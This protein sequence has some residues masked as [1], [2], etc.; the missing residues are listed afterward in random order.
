MTPII[1]ISWVFPN[2]QIGWR[3]PGIARAWSVRS[4]TPTR[5]TRDRSLWPSSLDLGNILSSLPRLPRLPKH[6]LTPALF[7]LHY[8]L[9]RLQVPD[10][11]IA[12]ESLGR[13]H[14]QG[15]RLE[16]S[17]ENDLC[18]QATG[19][20]ALRFGVWQE[21]VYLVLGLAHAHAH[22]HAHV[23]DHDHGDAHSYD[24]ARADAYT[25]A[26]GRC[27]HI[28]FII[29]DHAEPVNSKIEHADC[30]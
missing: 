14:P 25:Q 21:K 7:S 13:N 26:H 23:D 20:I 12:S 27:R 17:L 19:S 11:G 5:S 15:S 30:V 22:A 6:I 29:P 18:F 2:T 24:D 3:P 8:T 9:Q 28:F 1:P 16:N 10:P 4:V